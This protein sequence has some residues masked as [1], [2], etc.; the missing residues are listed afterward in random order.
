MLSPTGL[1]LYFTMF[2]QNSQGSRSSVTCELP[3]Y[4]ITPPT[5]RFEAAFSTT[6]NPDILKASVVVQDDSP[7]VEAY[8]GIGYGAGI[9]G[10]QIKRFTPVSLKKRNVSLKTGKILLFDI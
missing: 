6:S 5:G 2:A 7:I 10:D 3:T 1:P 9:Y 8:V 4:D